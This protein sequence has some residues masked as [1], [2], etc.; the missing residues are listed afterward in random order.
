MVSF[1][2]LDRRGKW[3]S[4]GGSSVRGGDVVF[5]RLKVSGGLG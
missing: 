3:R 2:S 4:G 5:S 1:L